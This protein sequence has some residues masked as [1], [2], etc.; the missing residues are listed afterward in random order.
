[1]SLAVV[2]ILWILSRSTGLDLSLL[3][4]YLSR[5]NSLRRAGGMLGYLQIGI[6]P[7]QK[8]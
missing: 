7:G 2:I 1:M 8:F 5:D 4:I 3:K 6:K